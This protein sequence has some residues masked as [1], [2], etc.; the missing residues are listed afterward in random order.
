MKN[1]KQFISILSAATAAIILTGC[2]GEKVDGTSA[3]KL[4]NSLQSISQNIAIDRKEKF[5]NAL[6]TIKIKY[7][8]QPDLAKAID[9]MSADEVIEK[10]DDTNKELTT[11]KNNQLQ[12]YREKLIAKY[13][14]DAER[15]E[16]R[17]EEDRKQYP[18]DTANFL[19]DRRE[20]MI[21]L[22][23]EQMEKF[24]GMSAD[25]FEAYA[26]EKGWKPDYSKI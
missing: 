1:T 3:E 5:D 15:A 26:T 22:S 17:I 16:A 13:K 23:T 25:D 2:S 20:G 6:T 18:E 19:R 11:L 10:G 14:S 24:Q 9:G 7:R 4:T 21:K 12:E 8:S